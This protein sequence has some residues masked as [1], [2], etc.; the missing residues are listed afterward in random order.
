MKNRVLVYVLFVAALMACNPE[1]P[2]TLDKDSQIKIDVRQL[3]AGFLEAEFTPNSLAYY[4][5]SADKVVPD[6]DP[7]TYSKQFMQ[8]VLDSAYK[9]YINWRYDLLY[10]GVP[11]HQ[12]ASFKDHALQYGSTH[13]FANYLDPD[14]DYWLYAFVVNPETNK[15]VSKLFMQTV[16]TKVRS[17]IPCRFRY[18]IRGSWDYVY[19]IDTI[20]GEILPDFPYAVAT[21]DSVSL[22]KAVADWDPEMQ[23]PAFFFVDSLLHLLKNRDKHARIL[24]GVYAHNNDGYGDGTSNTY[25]EEGVTYYTGMGGVDGGLVEGQNGIYKFTWHEGMDVVF[26]PEQTLGWKRW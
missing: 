25:F 1:A 23:S 13:Y 2:Y 18:R 12:I 21:I 11:V 10:M 14:S 26:E 20:T 7:E 4:L 17:E 22:R 3:S 15:P 16:H 24:Y 9:E 6:T 5:V 19:P 8:L